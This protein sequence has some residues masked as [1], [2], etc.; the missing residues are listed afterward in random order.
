MS[1]AE[2]TALGYTGIGVR[3]RNLY[4]KGRQFQR[5]NRLEVHVALYP[6]EIIDRARSYCWRSICVDWICVRRVSLKSEIFCQVMSRHV[7]IMARGMTIV[8]RT[9]G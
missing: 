3:R 1:V 8:A 2:Q 9:A 5:G 7:T 6:F 4:T